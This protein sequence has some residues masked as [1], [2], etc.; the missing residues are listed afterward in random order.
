MM[1][2]ITWYIEGGEKGGFLISSLCSAFPQYIT[3]F[4]FRKI[5]NQ[6]QRI[7]CANKVYVLLHF[8]LKDATNQFK[9]QALFIWSSTIWETPFARPESMTLM[10]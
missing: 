1:F 4:A 2:N 3:S 9:T 5:T 8:K 6:K 10:L 7:N